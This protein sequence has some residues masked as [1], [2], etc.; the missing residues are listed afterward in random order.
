MK[1]I[2][3]I[4][5]MAIV[6]FSACSSHTH[7]VGAGPSTGLQEKARQYYI[8]FGLVPLNKVDTNSMIGDATNFRIE[9]TTGPADVLIGIAAGMIVPT[10]VSSRTVTVTK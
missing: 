2:F 9:T 3:M 10:T 7:T 1:K 6:I 5:F 4:S 8:L